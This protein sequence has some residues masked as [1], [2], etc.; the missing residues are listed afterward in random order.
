MK[1]VLPTIRILCY[2]ALRVD[3][4]ACILGADRYE[5]LRHKVNELWR[6]Y[7]IFNIFNQLP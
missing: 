6:S 3:D 1:Q 2:I 4:L 5:V 7:W